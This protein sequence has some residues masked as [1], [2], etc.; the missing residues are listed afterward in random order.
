MRYCDDTISVDVQLVNDVMKKIK[1]QKIINQYFRNSYINLTNSQKKIF[2]DKL[3][4]IC[5]Y[6]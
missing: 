2:W 4:D 3:Y 1:I 5:D 6:I